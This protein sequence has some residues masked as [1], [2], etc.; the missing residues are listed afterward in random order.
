MV[1]FII[2]C[3][4][5]V[6]FGIRLFSLSKINSD[7]DI[8]AYVKSPRLKITIAGLVLIAF[9]S[10]G[11]MGAASGGNDAVSFGVACLV[12]MIVGIVLLRR[13]LVYCEWC[14]TKMIK[15]ELRDREVEYGDFEFKNDY[16]NEL[17]ATQTTK[18]TY[19]YHCPNCGYWREII[20]TSKKK[21]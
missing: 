7:R 2:A 3:V 4:Y 5:V 17:T 12:I 6:P 16:S 21:V 15:G 11:I 10:L 14:G 9:A 13:R 1:I 19:R 20:H 8:V 18:E